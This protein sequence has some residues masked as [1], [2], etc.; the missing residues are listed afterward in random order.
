MEKISI[1]FNA[2][3]IKK[4]SD[5]IF[6]L[7]E[8]IVVSF[9]KIVPVY[10]DFYKP[11]IE[12][13]I[14]LANISNKDKILHVGCGSIPATSIN[15]VKKTDADVTAID[16]N[17]KCIKKA[18]S[19]ISNIKLSNKIKIIYSDA[20]NFP[21]EKFNL[22]IV[23]LGV[24]PYEEVLKYISQNMENDARIIVRTN[25]TVDGQLAEKDLMLKEIFKLD[26]IIYQKK[27]GLMISVL[28]SKK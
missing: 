1:K 21:L 6:I 2:D 3:N 22:I 5:L 13:E 20:L 7:I 8:N 25:S 14:A 16:K 17:I 26:R 11:M 4:L 27:N 15:I 12:N 24:K 19:L 28:L 23:S 10:L 9:D 18:Q